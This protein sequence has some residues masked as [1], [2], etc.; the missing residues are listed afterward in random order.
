MFIFTHLSVNYV[1]DDTSFS[2]LQRFFDSSFIFRALSGGITIWPLVYISTVW[3]PK[4]CYKRN[5]RKLNSLQNILTWSIFETRNWWVI[6]PS[7]QER[8]F[9]IMRIENGIWNHNSPIVIKS[10]A[11]FGW[12]KLAYSHRM[13]WNLFYPGNVILLAYFVAQML[14]CLYH[15]IFLT[16]RK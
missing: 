1:T 16:K 6:L 8:H 9:N 2:P 4:R 12:Y 7:V 11:G 10:V 14:Y 3:I 13:W 15:H 5:Y